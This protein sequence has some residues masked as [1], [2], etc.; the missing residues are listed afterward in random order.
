MRDPADFAG[1]HLVGSINIGLGGSYATWAGTLLDP[2]RDIVIVAD[3]GR[4]EEAAVRLGRIGFDQV[5]GYLDGGMG[6]LETRQDLVGRVERLTAPTL[7][8]QLAAEPSPVVVDVRAEGEWGGGHIDGSQNVP[9]NH[10]A[11]R[12]DEIPADRPIVVHCASDYRSSIAASV[13][14]L[15]GFDRVSALVGGIGA[16]EASGLE[17]ATSRR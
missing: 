4:E 9:L 7:A 17:T 16:W 13:L 12:L 8:Q 15:H 1:A 2:G 3:P 14:A 11:E 10:L 5:A 6:A